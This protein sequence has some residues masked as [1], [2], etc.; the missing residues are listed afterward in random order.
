MHCF[1][2]L[3][4]APRVPILARFLCVIALVAVP[5]LATGT[6]QQSMG[7][8]QALSGVPIESGWRF[9]PGDDP[10]WSDPAFDDSGWHRVDFP[11]RWGPE[12]AAAEARQF[13]WY[14]LHLQFDLAGAGQPEKLARLGVSLG[15]MLSA[16]DV[17]AGGRRLGGVGELPPAADPRVDYN[18]KLVLAIPPSAISADGHLVLA[19]RVWSGNEALLTHFGGGVHGGQFAIGEFQDLFVSRLVAAI[20][21]LLVSVVYLVFGLY[22][23]YLY[24]RNHSLRSFLWFGLSGLVISVYGLMLSEWRYFLDWDF[25]AYKKLEF[26]ML[27]LIPVL[28]VQAVWSLLEEPVSRPMRWFQLSFLL[29]ALVLTAVPGLDVHVVT[30]HAWELW[31]LGVPGCTAWL[32]LK[33]L[34]SGNEEA[35]V[36]GVGICLFTLTCVHDALVDLIRLDSPR[37]LPWGFLAMAVTMAVSLGNRF[38]RMMKHLEAEVSDRRAE[39]IAANQQLSEA[40]LIDPLTGIFNRRGFV[41][42]AELEIKRVFRHG[43]SFCIVLADVDHFKSINDRLGHLCGDRVLTAL[44]TTLQGAMRGSDRLARWGGEEFILLLPETSI[45]GAAVVAEKLREQVAQTL[46]PY[47]GERVRATMTFGVVLFRRGESLDACIAR[48]DRALYQGKHDGRNRV[49]V[50]SPQGI[51]RVH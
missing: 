9:H 47:E 17:F 28:S 34:R 6:A 11:H 48:A 49:V 21:G 16:F 23:L 50:G 26:A 35:R 51:K 20:P 31:A 44:A 30:L 36:V 7:L 37:I 43:R 42:E 40:A 45:A 41:A 46:I 39:L 1:R 8:A 33:K 19:M 32:L 24:S 10:A 15:S 14:R 18:R 4:C 27:Y 13:G 3:R 5:T 29:L 2:F 22:Y 38:T 25:L 12:E